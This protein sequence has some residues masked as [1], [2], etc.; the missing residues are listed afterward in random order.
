LYRL[1]VTLQPPRRLQKIAALEVAI[2]PFVAV[3]I[4][5]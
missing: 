2:T 4:V 1:R 5:T 3:T